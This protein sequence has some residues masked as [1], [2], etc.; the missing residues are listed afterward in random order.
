MR[1]CETACARH[2][3]DGAVA[4]KD[5]KR[6]AADHV[7]STMAD[8]FK[9]DEIP[10]TPVSK[11]VAVIGAGP[12]GINCA[13]HLLRKGH[14][15]DVFEAEDY[16][17]GMARLGIPAYRLPNHLLETETE[18]IERLGGHY[19]YNCALGRDYTID[20]LFRRGYD[21][22]LLYTSPSPRD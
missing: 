21:A 22:C 20:S 4:I 2:H 14:H 1:P 5:L 13:Y 3:V 9:K 8:L 6:Y 17:G 15:V 18:V 11:R 19:H 12:A 10:D 7:G 16:A